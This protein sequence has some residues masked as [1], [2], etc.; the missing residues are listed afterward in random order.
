MLILRRTLRIART[1]LL[2]LI[3]L[4]IALVATIQIQ[5]RLLRRDA[6]RLDGEIM[7]CEL[8]KTPG[9]DAVRFFS[10][11]GNLVQTTGN[12]EAGNCTMKIRAF[13]WM[14][15]HEFFQQHQWLVDHCP[16]IGGRNMAYEGDITVVNGVVAKKRFSLLTEYITPPDESGRR[17]YHLREGVIQTLSHFGDTQLERCDS[18]MREH[19]EY[20][21][22]SPYDCTK[23]SRMEIDFTPFAPTNEIARIT[24]FN[25]DCMT[26][27]SPCKKIGDVLPAAAAE[28]EAE[29]A[30][31]R[32]LS[33][34]GDDE[35]HDWWLKTV[36]I[37]ARES[38]NVVIAEVVSIGHLPVVSRQEAPP[39]PNA[40]AK[41]RL[42]E[43][44]KGA[45]DWE[46]DELRDLYVGKNYLTGPPETYPTIRPGARF[47]VLFESSFKIEPV[48]NFQNSVLS[49]ND[50]NLVQV[51]FGISRDFEAA[52][53]II[54]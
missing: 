5:Q 40:G 52:F 7:S 28:Y 18:L 44:L 53:P 20:C 9:A 49:L 14:A 12:C 42:V 39:K 3:G 10:S 37:N 16:W 19:P 8:L 24:R 22:T 48:R 47:I 26:R 54:Q 29:A 27:W 41:L 35:L 50:A 6:E 36:W 25:F 23:C 31:T 30:R 45:K 15:R 33:R 46:P 11:W 13:D 32:D 4:C 2:C 51:R 17:H 21:V 1:L 34:S 38:E 43:R